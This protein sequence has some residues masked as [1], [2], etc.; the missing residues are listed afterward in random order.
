MKGKKHNEPSK[1]HH[2]HETRKKREDGGGVRSYADTD[3][4]DKA[5]NNVYAGKAGK[6]DDS[7]K[8]KRPGRKAGGKVMGEGCKPRL[9]RPGRKRGGRVG[10]EM[11]PLSSA[12][13]TSA[14]G[15]RG[16]LDDALD[17]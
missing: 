5:T 9:D 12:A 13:K 4:G 8:S 3:G 16:N 2:V 17:D 15:G 14:P 10:A 6:V 7:A 1:K 11:S